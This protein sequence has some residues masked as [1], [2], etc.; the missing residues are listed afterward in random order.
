MQ[1]NSRKCY[2]ISHTQKRRRP[3]QATGTEGHHSEEEGRERADGYEP[4]HYNNGED[5]F[6]S[7]P[8][9][10]KKRQNCGPAPF[11]RQCFF[12]PHMSKPDSHLP[13]G[14]F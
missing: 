4:R 10:A 13:T 2:Q 8:H 14:L 5:Y 3:S 1:K 9:L 12:F 7:L 11:S 6:S